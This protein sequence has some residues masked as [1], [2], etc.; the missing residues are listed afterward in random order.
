MDP[1]AMDMHIY[2]DSTA[3]FTDHGMKRVC[4]QPWCPV[5]GPEQAIN[6][7]NQCIWLRIPFKSI[8]PDQ[9]LSWLVIENP[10]INRVKVWFLQNDTA[11]YAS[12]LTGD[13]TPFYTR[14]YDARNFIFSLDSLPADGMLLLAVDNRATRL[15]LPLHFQSNAYFLTYQDFD[16][17][18]VL[19][20][21]GFIFFLLIF[22]VY[23]FFSSGDSAFGWYAAYLLLISMFV[24][25]DV[26]LFFQ[27]LYPDWPEANNVI[28][29]STFAASIVPMLLFFN[30]IIGVAS[31]STQLDKFNKILTGLY[32]VIFIVAVTTASLKIDPAFRQQ[33]V[34]ISRFITL[35]VLT[36]LL[37]ESLYFLMKGNV[38]ALFS[39]GS[40]FSLTFFFLAYLGFRLDRLPQS[41][42]TSYG[43]YWG[44]AAD[45]F[46][47]GL[48]LAWRF[49]LMRQQVAQLSREKAERQMQFALEISA[50]KQQQMQQV[51]A[52]LHDRIGAL[53]DVLLLSVTNMPMD[54]TGRRDISA[55]IVSI[56]EE[57][58]Q[59]SHFYSPALIHSNGLKDSITA[60]IGKLSNTQK[61]NFHLDWSGS[62]DIEPEQI[63]IF[64]YFC[65]QEMF[66]NMLKHSECSQVTV[67]VINEPVKT[68]LYFEDD[69]TGF[70]DLE[71]TL[72][73]G[74]KSMKRI[75]GLLGGHLEVSSVPEE[76]FSLSVELAK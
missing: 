7:S 76:G 67:Q 69:S 30:R 37:V 46:F 50:W 42:V 41:V 22:N 56:S 60:L 71:N 64:L 9:D 28:R 23:L 70:I 24:C 49:R 33:W 59:Y 3:D 25:M 12:P 40:F 43:V 13:A 39:L 35:V 15:S 18:W 29:L 75:V 74:L 8:P 32:F 62:D 48:S 10:H 73:N 21:L 57:I 68:F 45:A 54:E 20:F 38:M 47:M 14:P 6:Y 17:K 53:M 31:Y 36:V 52:F 55:N 65:V 5:Q 72:G 63:R 11:V 27:V 58:R 16:F 34:V 4:Q 66:Q 51:T 2:F 26:G 44:L 61:I 1:A 19:F